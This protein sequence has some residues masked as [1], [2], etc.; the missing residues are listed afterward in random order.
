MKTFFSSKTKIQAKNFTLLAATMMVTLTGCAS[1]N[2][3]LKQSDNLNTYIASATIADELK[4][5][6]E[7]N[8]WQQLNDTTLNALVEEALT[9]NNALIA[10]GKRLQA[11]YRQLGYEQHQ[12][13]PQGGAL[14]ASTKESV[15]NVQTESAKAGLG[16]SWQLDL[17]GRIDELISAA[18]ANALAQA[19]LQRSLYVEIVSGVVQ[20]YLNWHGSNEKHR[21]IAMQISALEES[22]EVLK[23]RV[24]EGYSSSLDLNRAYAQLNQQQ[25]LLPL[26]EQARFNN[27]AALAVLTGR[28]ASDI[29]IPDTKT[30]ADE[31]RTLS[32]YAK[33]QF[34][35]DKLRVELASPS[36]AIA[37]RPDIS[38]ALYQL[39]KEQALSDSARAA[40]FPSINLTAFA[41]VL[42]VDSAG[43][44]NTVNHWQIKPQVEWSLLSYPA[45]MAQLDTQLLFTEA[46]YADYKQAVLE[47]IADSERSLNRLLTQTQQHQFATKRFEYANRAF[48]QATAMYEEGQVPYLTLLDARQDV[49]IAQQNAVDSTVASL[50]SRVEA[51]K[52]FNGQWSHALTLL[53]SNGA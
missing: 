23:I 1:N 52:A 20:S 41:G 50:I 3:Y 46:A 24:E 10:S 28:T 38:Q 35:I 44:S 33:K 34:T 9:Q 45:L 15:D 25:A 19:E 2:D 17:F 32:Q 21:I 48:E 40:L 51:F 11:A 49:L 36:L 8:W 4:G 29:N 26:V 13:L 12:Y 43:L 39:A 53:Q 37:K 7:V 22:I 27:Q 42:S 18:N 31:L 14:V 30:V 6:S 5:V 47:A 16:L